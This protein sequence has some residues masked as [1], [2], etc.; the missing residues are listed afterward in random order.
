MYFKYGAFYLTATE[1][2]Q[3][4]NNTMRRTCLNLSLIINVY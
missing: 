1:A 2:A 4:S 3:Y